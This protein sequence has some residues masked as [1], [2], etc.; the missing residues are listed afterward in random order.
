M[1]DSATIEWL[2]ARA[3]ITDVVHRYAQIIRG[4]DIADCLALFMTDATFEVRDAVRGDPASARTRSK[5]SGHD[6]ILNYVSQSVA[7]ARL[8]PLIHNLL[9][10]VNGREATSSAV[11]TAVVPSSGQTMTG[12]YQDAFRE[13]NGV[14]RFTARTYTIF[15]PQT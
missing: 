15:R 6:A 5:V 13:E 2:A 4:G 1:T 14:W 11:M 7:S 10:D 12:E 8:C 3:R 9:I